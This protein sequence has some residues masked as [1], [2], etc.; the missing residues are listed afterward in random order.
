MFHIIALGSLIVRIGD[1]LDFAGTN[2][3]CWFSLVLSLE[4]NLSAW[5][6]RI[7]LEIFAPILSPDTVVF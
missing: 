6:L 2:F 3:S 4:I 5:F 1:F 7:S